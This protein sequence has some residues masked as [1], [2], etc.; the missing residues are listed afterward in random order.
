MINYIV[1][2]LFVLLFI[3]TSC[4]IVSIENDSNVPPYFYSET[5]CGN[6]PHYPNVGVTT[7]KTS[8]SPLYDII[9]PANEYDGFYE[10]PDKDLI[11]TMQNGCPITPEELKEAFKKKYP[12]LSD[13]DRFKLMKDQMDKMEPPISDYN[14]IN[15]IAT[16]LG[17]CN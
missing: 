2:F 4:K 8:H 9:K 17:L 6:R 13:D 14:D 7:Y 15:E 10:V 1:I 11:E 5:K 12:D 16:K 3:C